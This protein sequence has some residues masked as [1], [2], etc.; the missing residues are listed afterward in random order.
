MEIISNYAVLS[1]LN[2]AILPGSLQSQCDVKF[3]FIKG[4][5]EKCFLI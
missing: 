2:T 3:L 5:L 4:N 1:F